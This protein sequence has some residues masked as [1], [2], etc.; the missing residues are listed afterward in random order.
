MND[1][2]VL[3]PE[4]DESKPVNTER[5]IEYWIASSDKDYEVM[6]GLIQLKHNHWALYLGQL[7]I[8]KLLKAYYVKVY[9]Q[10]PPFIHDLEKL[11]AKSKLSYTENQKHALITISGFNTNARY[12]NVKF[13]FYKMCTGEYTEYWV[14]QINQLRTWIKEQL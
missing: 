13:L 9:Q 6:L 11:A 8:E 5:I 14:E 4:N 1:S 10:H 7:V 12:D 2:D 3:L